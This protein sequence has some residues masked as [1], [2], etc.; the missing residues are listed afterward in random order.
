MKYIISCAICLLYFFGQAQK[1]EIGEIKTIKSTF[2]DE[3]RAY[4]VYLPEHYSDKKYKDQRYPVIYLL[5]GEKYFHVASGIVKNLSSGY[6]PQMPEC[7]V[8][9]IKN[10]ERSRDLTPTHVSKLSY[11]SG[12][13]G[14]FDAFINKELIPEINKNYKTLNFRILVGHS[15]GGLF[16]LNTLFKNTK[17]FNAYVAIDP[18]LWWDNS[19]L[20]KELEPILKT[21]EFTGNTLFF[22]NANSLGNPKK[23]SKQHFAH[24][25]AKKKLI[26][27]VETT[28]PKNLNYNIKYYE[29]ED[30]GSVVLSALVDAFRWVFRGFRINVKE[31]IENPSLLQKHYHDLSTRLGFSFQPQSAYLDRVVNL[32]V[33]RE[34]KENI[35]K[36]HNIIKKLYPE[37]KYLINK[38]QARF[39]GYSQKRF[40]I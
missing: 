20:V 16:T 39:K 12:G 11:K 33:K 2:L 3:A 27:L 24:F 32:S 37:N 15:F 14:K 25:E 1:I 34:T 7:I 22:A 19:I 31:L 30:H 17:S 21:K 6:Y 38:Y 5:D 18:S 40:G 29:D 10:T 23:P 9:A 28:I 8:V 4:W 35:N 36:L 26:N 13:S